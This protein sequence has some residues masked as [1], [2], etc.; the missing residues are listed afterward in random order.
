MSATAVRPTADGV[1]GQKNEHC[2][3]KRGKGAYWGHKWE[4]KRESNRI[5][6]ETWKGDIRTAIDDK[7]E[8]KEERRLG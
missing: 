7:P 2:G 6:R 5:R 3:P 8:N 1:R 4:A